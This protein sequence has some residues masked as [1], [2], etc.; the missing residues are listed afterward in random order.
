V[1]RNAL[2]PTA[3]S[4]GFR[5]LGIRLRGPQH[6]RR[7]DSS[8]C[9]RSRRQRGT[10]WPTARKNRCPSIVD[11]SGDFNSRPRPL[12][13][14]KRDHPLPPKGP[15]NAMTLMTAR[16]SVPPPEV[17]A[18]SKSSLPSSSANVI[19]PTGLKIPRRRNGGGGDLQSSSRLMR[20]GQSKPRPQARRQ[21]GHLP[22]RQPAILSAPPVPLV[23]SITDV[24]LF[25]IDS[26]IVGA[27]LEA[28]LS[29][30]GHKALVLR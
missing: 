17:A 16:S 20:R 27:A 21:C 30:Q 10:S 7:A 1:R 2:Y 5:S 4:Q 3:S 12:V 6:L 26:R 11:R 29:L 23:Q 15:L 25:E 14:G 19:N 24:P 9:A 8:R 22:R 18:A 13:S 28:G